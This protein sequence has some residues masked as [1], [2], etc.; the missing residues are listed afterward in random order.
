LPLAA[1]F[2]QPLGG[3]PNPNPNLKSTEVLPDHRVV[4]CIYAPKANAV[5]L[6]GDFVT[7]GPWTAGAM[8]KDDEGIWLLTVGPLVPDFYSYSFIGDGVQTRWSSRRLPPGQHVPG[9]GTGYVDQ[10]AALSE[11][12]HAVTLPLERELCES[13]V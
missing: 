10:L 7:R 12:L 6:T 9:A 3:Q 8:Q 4:F 1:A 13:A 5:T 11:G 2:V